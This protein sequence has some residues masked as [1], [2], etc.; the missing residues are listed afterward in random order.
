[1]K[2]SRSLNFSAG[3]IFWLPAKNEIANKHL[4]AAET[5]EDGCFNHPVL[6]LAVMP[7]RKEVTILVMTSFGGKDLLEKHPRSPHIRSH[8]LP[9]YPSKVHPDNGSQLFLVNDTKLDRNSYINTEVQR[10]I[11]TVLLKPTRHSA[12]KLRADSYDFLIRYIGFSPPPELSPQPHI[13]VFPSTPNA[14]AAPRTWANI[15]RSAPVH[16]TRPTPAHYTYPTPT[17]STQP[18]PTHSANTIPTP[19]HYT[20][21]PLCYTRPIPTQSTH[22][23]NRSSHEHWQTERTPLLPTVHNRTMYHSE[24]PSGSD[25]GVS[26][27]FWFVVGVTIVAWVIWKAGG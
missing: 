12:C 19:T 7:N 3:A 20:H 13:R 22:S 11:R 24:E 25:S 5:I 4:D 1:M 6:I 27:V 21:L 23:N 16:Y 10:T 26:R 8:H 2:S 17:Y 14:L 9:I 15:A 18:V